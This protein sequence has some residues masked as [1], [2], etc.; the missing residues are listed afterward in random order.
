MIKLRHN[1]MF[2]DVCL[3]FRSQNMHFICYCGENEIMNSDKL[4]A[5]L[6]HKEA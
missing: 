1:K 5:K 6:D 4:V 2:Y 3:L